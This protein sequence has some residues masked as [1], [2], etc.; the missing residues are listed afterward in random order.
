MAWCR[1]VGAAIT[2]AS[3]L[4][5]QAGIVGAGFGVA[6][7][8][9]PLAVGRQRI[10]DGHQR[11][12]V[13]LGEF[14]GMESAQ[15]SGADDGDSQFVHHSCQLVSGQCCGRQLATDR[16][17]PL[18]TALLTPLSAVRGRGRAGP[19]AGLGRNSAG[20]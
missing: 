4:V 8:G 17:L 18:T 11:D 13:A 20:G 14:L 6:F 2:A 10:D 16:L 15:S 9:H 5:E 3:M 1:L 7:G 12:V 19:R